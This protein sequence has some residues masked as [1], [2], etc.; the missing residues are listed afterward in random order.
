MDIRIETAADFVGIRGVEEDAFPTRAEADLVDRLRTDGD[1]VFSLLAILEDQIVG[2]VMFSRMRTPPNTLGLG[3]VAVST[4]H[5]RKGIAAS[6]IREGLRRATVTG[7]KGVFVLGDPA[8]YCRFGF[9]AVLAAG[10]TSRYSGPH[11]LALVLQPDG[12]PVEKGSLEYAA[13]FA[14]LE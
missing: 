2:H 14:A 1:A 13:A 6:L 7:W 8:Y 11:L 12:L 4:P 10:F 3:R 9:D 5:R